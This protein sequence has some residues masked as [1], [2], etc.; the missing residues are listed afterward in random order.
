MTE[1]RALVSIDGYTRLAE[2]KDDDTLA[3]VVNHADFTANNTVVVKNNAGAITAVS[4]AST[5]VLANIGAGLAAVPLA[6][7]KTA[8][9][10]P[11]RTVDAVRTGAV[12][13]APNTIHPIDV[14]AVAATINPPEV[15]TADMWFTVVDAY[16]SAALHNITI[17]FDDANQLYYGAAGNAVI[18][19]N[20]SV[21]TFTYINGTIGWVV[22]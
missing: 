21:K 12:T 17:A 10:V 8:L 18:T 9:Q 6:D 20:G 1:L 3:R 5:T 14:R 19:S 11:A 15:P 13:A 22:Q 16:A 7:L 2:L 4:L